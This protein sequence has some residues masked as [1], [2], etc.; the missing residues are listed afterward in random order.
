M[1]KLIL[2]FLIVVSYQIGIT[3]TTSE[4]IFY[5]KMM[6]STFVL[7]ILDTDSNRAQSHWE[8]TEKLGREI[9]A[10]ISSWDSLSFTSAINRNAGIKPVKVPIRLFN[11]I[12]RSIKVSELTQGAFDI[13]Y[14]ALDGIWD[15]T[16]PKNVIPD[17]NTI[18]RA[19]SLVNYKEIILNTMDTSVYLSN[20]GMKIG[21][22]AI[23]KG[24]L[25]DEITRFLKSKGIKAG[26]VN[27]GGDLMTW[28][29]P[30][31][32]TAWE[33]GLANPSL[34]SHLLAKLK[35]KDQAIVTSGDYEKYIEWKGI[36]YAHI[37]DPKSGYPV[38]YLNSVTVLC[39]SAELADALATAVFVMGEKKGIALIN[40][41]EGIDAVAVKGSNIYAS[42]LIEI[43]QT[44]TYTGEFKIFADS[45]VFKP[46]GTNRWMPISFPNQREVEEMYHKT[47]DSNSQKVVL[48]TVKG[49]IVEEKRESK[50][51]HVFKSN[52]L[53][54]V[55]VKP[56]K[57]L[58][59]PIKDVR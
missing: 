14:A 47:V 52:Q 46:C 5:S 49:T 45:P 22:G 17:S 53:I 40:Q 23:G 15:F 48:L 37:L 21:F 38:T 58:A 20:K 4:H 29:T 39:P 55:E 50:T 28:G 6:G 34:K 54:S 31:Y 1:N 33:I 19:V 18:H 30:L 56:C 3:Q 51:I 16:N 27:A 13:S 8:M 10:E 12:Q 35:I 36:K 11:L 41:L 57:I 2:T 9:E 32:D 43:E 25:A 59:K 7:T 26:I 44:K 42:N 24:F